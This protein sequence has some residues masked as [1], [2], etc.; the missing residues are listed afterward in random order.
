VAR[1]LAQKLGIKAADRVAAI[2]APEDFAASLEL[3]T[4]EIETD[5]L[6]GTFDVVIVFVKNRRAIEDVAMQAMSATEPG[7]R[8]WFAYPKQSSGVATDI[9]R[10][11]GWDALNEAGWRPVTQV[12]IDDTWSALRFRPAFEVGS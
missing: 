10:D 9:N 3:D 1:T 4:G 8:L 5:N 6:A 2:A 11:R 12:A 7:S